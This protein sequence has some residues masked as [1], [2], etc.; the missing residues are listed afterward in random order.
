MLCKTGWKVLRGLN[1]THKG[2]ELALSRIK[3]TGII[4]VYLISNC[5][6]FSMCIALCDH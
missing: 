3:G 6:R 2:V 1:M 4:C 5:T